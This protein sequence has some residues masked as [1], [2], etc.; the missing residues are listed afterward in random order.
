MSLN[1]RDFLKLMGG[2]A[3]AVTFPSVLIQGCKRAL[4]K[5]A[6]RTN[7]IWIQAQS[8]SGC[9]VS[10]LNKMDPSIA[11]VITEHISLNYHQTI[12]AG[13]GDVAVSVLDEAV[14]KQ[15]KDFVLIVE[16]SI[17]TKS[18]E[19]CTIGEVRG[20]RIGAREWVEKLGANAA[21]VVSV[22][23]CSAFGG[24]PA[25]EMRD[26]SG[27]PTGAISVAQ[28]LKGK[29]VINIPGCPPH[30]DW[31]VLSL[32]AV[33]AAKEKGTTVPLDEYNRPKAFYGKT[34]HEQCE[35]LSYYKSGKFAK[36]WGD[37][38]CLYNVGCLGMDSCCDIPARKWVGGNNSCTGCGAGCIGCTEDVFPDFGKRGVFKHLNAR[39][40]GI[41][42]PEHRGPVF[43]LR[44]GGVF[45][46]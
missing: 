16:G 33:L 19:F 25:A 22:G 11:S 7:V 1:R 12:M 41:I 40:E 24:W 27:N 9:S 20:R 14:E 2:T 8:C 5:A 31:I 34:V 44:N 42:K 46:G 36:F 45:N 26:G 29:T 28:L 43:N 21:A 4:E 39:N 13:T 38:G 6:Q 35:R 18:I 30:P 10:L 37:E 15:R 17:P 3:A 23:T 32:L